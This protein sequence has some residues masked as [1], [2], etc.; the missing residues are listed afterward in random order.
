MDQVL[1]FIKDYGL[2]SG[3]G[4]VVI[5]ALGWLIKTALSKS[6]IQQ[7]QRVSG[8]GTG[9]QAGRDITVQERKDA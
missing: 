1:T 5:S 4:V 2:L 6:S 7:D 8:G 3:A 9:Y